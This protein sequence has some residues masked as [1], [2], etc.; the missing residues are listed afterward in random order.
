MSRPTKKGRVSEPRHIRIYHRITGSRAW[1][2]ASGNAIK[3]LIAVMRL[4]NGENNGS[5]FMS[6]RTGAAET[7]LSTK[8]VTKAFA[9]LEDLGFLASTERGH[10]ARKGGPAT[11]WRLTW[12]AWPGHCGPTNDWEKWTPKKPS[13]NKLRRENF[14]A[15]VVDSTTLPEIAGVTVVNS[16]TTKPAK[17]QSA[18][19]ASVVDSATEII[20]PSGDALQQQ[21]ELLRNET[22]RWLIATATRQKDLAGLIGIS[23]S[24]LSRFLDA[25]ANRTLPPSQFDR[26]ASIIRDHAKKSAAA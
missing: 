9:E 1:Q 3:L 8:T 14:P 4:N 5:L 10:F 13:C 21:C 24:R 18:V 23:E 11:R 2:A 7:G 6:V 22:R 17:P 15:A 20:L 25:T 12:V 16:T 26:L 19:V